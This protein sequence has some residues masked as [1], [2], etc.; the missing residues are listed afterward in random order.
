LVDADVLTQLTDSLMHVLRNAVDH[1]IEMP[2]VR[3]SN[4]KNPVGNIT[5][6][7]RRSRNDLEVI[8]LDDG[9]GLDFNRIRA[10]AQR[11]Q[12]LSEVELDNEQA[13][14]RVLLS[15]GF[16]TRSEVTQLSGRGVGLDVVN[17]TVRDLNGSMSI[18]S[19]RDGGCRIGLR[20]PISLITSHA[21]LVEAGKKRYAIPTQQ[22]E[23]ILPPDSG[24]FR[25]INNKLS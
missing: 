2:D 14:A 6:K 11:K 19:G 8:C 22:L 10:T 3:E 16:T 24:T 5:L 18:R 7:F 21:L 25:E 23:Q 4:G 17:S 9:G 20:L 1:G 13:L 12:L 15:P